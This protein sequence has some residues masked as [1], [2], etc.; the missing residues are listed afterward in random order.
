MNPLKFE[1]VAICGFHTTL[2]SILDSAVGKA[3]AHYCVH[4]DYQGAS[5]IGWEIKCGPQQVIMITNHYIKLSISSVS[6]GPVV[7]KGVI[8][9]RLLFCTLGIQFAIA[10]WPF[11]FLFFLPLS[12]SFL[13]FLFNLIV[14]LYKIK[15]FIHRSYINFIFLSCHNAS[16]LFIIQEIIIKPSSQANG[17]LL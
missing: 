2:T 11:P 6:R 10:I 4:Y 14:Q 12:L 16:H 13:R 17:K 1:I 3:L 15:E 9:R 5:L 7:A 8:Q